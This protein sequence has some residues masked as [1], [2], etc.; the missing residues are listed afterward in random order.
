MDLSIFGYYQMEEILL[1]LERNLDVSVY[2]N[3]EFSNYQMEVIRLGLEK[4]LDVSVY[5]KPEYTHVQ[6]EVIRLGLKNA[7][8]NTPK[9]INFRKEVSI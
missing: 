2:T 6:M 7:S 5:A 9:K 3:P 1:G 4:N 8:G